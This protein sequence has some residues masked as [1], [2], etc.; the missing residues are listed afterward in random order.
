RIASGHWSD[1]VGLRLAPLLRLGYALAIALAVSAVLVDAPLALLLPVFVVAGSLSSGWNGLSF[2]AAAELAGET[3]AGAALGLQQASLALA[4]ALTPVVFVAVV[5][6][7]SWG[8][9]FAL[10]AAVALV[11]TISLVALSARE[12]EAAAV[13]YDEVG[14]S[15]TSG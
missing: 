2:A 3:A 12:A 5:D 11:G 15:S 8:A 10:A 6:R 13:A 1:R 4:A 9:G 7:A 14:P